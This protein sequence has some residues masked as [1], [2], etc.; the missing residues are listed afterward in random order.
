MTRVVQRLCKLARSAA[1]VSLP[2][3]LYL[4]LITHTTKSDVLEWPARGV[5]D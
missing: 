1:D 3:T 4:G 5:G 2:M